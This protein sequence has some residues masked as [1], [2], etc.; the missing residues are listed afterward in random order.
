M[1]SQMNHKI[2]VKI[3]YMRLFLEFSPHCDFFKAKKGKKNRFEKKN[4]DV[5]LKIKKIETHQLIILQTI[6]Y[7][8]PQC[9]FF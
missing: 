4:A 5:K 2:T 8:N 3:F 1:T 9:L 7:F 6:Y